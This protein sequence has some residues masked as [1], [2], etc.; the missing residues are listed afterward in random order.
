MATI[1]LPDTK[2]VSEPTRA[3]QARRAQLLETVKTVDAYEFLES[4]AAAVDEY[5]RSSFA[6]SAVGPQMGIMNNPYALIALGGYGRG[7]QCVYSDI[8][9]LFLFENRVPAEAEAL[10]REIIYP[11]WDMGL[12]VGHATRSIKECIQLARQ[13]LEVLTALLDGRFICGMSPL[14]HRLMERL[15]HKLISVNPARLI[16]ALEESNQRRHVRFGDSAYLLEPNLKEGQGGLRDYHTM[17]WVARIQSDAKSSRDLEYYGYLS[18]DEY[19]ELQ[20]SLSFVWS[21]RNQLH[22]LMGR[23]L[24][25][26][27]LEH[28]NRLAEVMNVSQVNGHLPVEMLM[29]DLHGHME[30]IKQCYRMFIYE[31]DQR[32]R[33]KR[34]NKALKETLVPGLKFNRGLLNFVSP[35]AILKEP[36]LLIYIFVESAVHKAPLS[37]EARRLIKEFGDMV[38]EPGFRH[39]PEVVEAFERVLARP[40]SGFNVL[41]DMLETGFLAHFIPEFKGVTNRIQFDQYHLY[42]V[43]RHLLLSVRHLKTIATARGDGSGDPLGPKIYH[44]IRHKK[45]LLWATL[46]HDIGKAEAAGGHSERGA[47]MA[48]RILT[49]RGLAES[50]VETAAFLVR[51]HLTLFETATRRDINDEETALYVAR[52]IVKPERLKMLYLL[53]VADAMATGPKAW[54]DWTASLMRS[55]FLR[56]LNVMEKGELVSKKALRVIAEK[57]ERILVAS[58]SAQEREDNLRLME[59]MSPRYLLHTP[60][61]EIPR[62]IELF[63]RLGERPFVWRIDP[64]A[65]GKTRTITLCAKDRPGLLSR[66]AGI[67]TL[68]SIN[69]LDFRIFTWRNN[70]A[71]DIFDVQAPPDLIFEDERWQRVERHLLAALNDEMD[72]SSELADKQG[73]FRTLQAKEM[74]KN[75]PQKVII[76]NETSSFFTII[77]VIAWD[78]PGLLYRIT[79]AIFRCRLDIW[80][81]KIANQVD[82]VVDVFYVRSFDGEKVDSAEEESQIRET[83][84]AILQ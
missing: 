13:D 58:R 73:G 55:L 31:L 68:N 10:V 67:L 79:D 9:L 22:L 63:D 40:V 72:L 41:N 25:Q 60:S 53:S 56:T 34:K 57:K 3:F 70:V 8:D 65:D 46:L 15:R 76:D 4:H 2:A 19:A 84:G 77:E 69:I 16:A 51:E 82:Q 18:N 1:P 43:A 74:T 14:F 17:L 20:R 81:A 28:Q 35:E 5:F 64:S 78:F 27:H 26:L 30:F 23:K 49:E 33:L 44:E 61:Q 54:N 83:I 7:E 48:A 6:Q 38:D 21:V 66:V 47:E 71:L 45:A 42:P 36:L 11:L 52:R 62:H 39:S 32:K 80:V 24:D 37:A 59:F 29:G 50:D 12:E 75:R